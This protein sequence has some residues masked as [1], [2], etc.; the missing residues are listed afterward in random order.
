MRNNYKTNF[1]INC[2]RVK[3]V[4]PQLTL[5]FIQQTDFKIVGSITESHF[6]YKL[7]RQICN[8]FKQKC[9]FI[10]LRINPILQI[11]NDLQSIIYI[12]F[13][14]GIILKLCVY[15]CMYIHIPSPY[16]RYTQM[17]LCENRNTATYRAR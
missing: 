10:K 6:K 11:Y 12:F 8:I 9:Y 15:F 16:I 7:L 5:K 14:V 13:N 1:K 2:E 3:K 17:H 4:K